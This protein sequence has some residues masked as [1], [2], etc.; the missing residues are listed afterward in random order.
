MLPYSSEEV[1]VLR[2]TCDI[3]T[4]R[5]PLQGQNDMGIAQRLRSRIRHTQTSLMNTAK[6]MSGIASLR[7]ITPRFKS[8][9]KQRYPFVTTRA[10]GI[11][12]D[13]VCAAGSSADGDGRDS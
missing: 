3:M 10:V 12:R 7:R 1:V 2:S 13:R 11:L 4:T 9:W 8:Y 5:C 6:L